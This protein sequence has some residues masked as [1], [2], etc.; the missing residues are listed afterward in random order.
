[1]IV[2]KNA[3]DI[4]LMAQ[5]CKITAGALQAAGEAIQ[6]GVT[7]AHVDTVVKKFITSHGAKPSF[8]GYGGFP[9]SACISVNDTVIHGI[10]GHEVIKDGDI[11]SVDV[12]AYYKGFHGDSAYTFAVGTIDA[13][14]K[15]LLEV[16][17]ES[18]QAAIAV[19]APGK[20]I[21]DISNAV[22]TVVEAAGFSIV[23]D[24]VGHGVGQDL[25]E[26]PQVPNYGIPGRGPR[27]VPGM[28]IA[29][30]P[31]VN[32]GGYAVRVLDDDW[33]VKTVDHSMAAH[34]EHTVVITNDGCR[35]LTK[36]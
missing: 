7:T 5:A 13:E 30:E 6:P 31:M 1:M 27:L 35:V 33:T 23:R 11:V 25:H 18:L 10:P 20:R 3:A 32:A 8:L 15:R 26:D 29:I 12:G 24:F 9:A 16:T 28:T 21:G 34:F 19:A 4:E 14:T 36:L 17:K 22:Q 2:V